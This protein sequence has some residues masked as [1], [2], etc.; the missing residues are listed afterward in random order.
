MSTLKELQNFELNMVKDIVKIFDKNNIFYVICSGTLL[1][2]IRH[3][4]FIPWDDDVDIMLPAKDYKKALK[5]L[6]KELGDK[7]FLQNYHTDKKYNLPWSQIR[8]DGT[9]SMPKNINYDI[10]YGMCF[11]LFPVIGYYKSS[12]L[13]NL[14]IKLCGL[15]RSLLAVDYIKAIDEECCGK[16][17]IISYIPRIV[18]HLFVDIMN[19]FII[20]DINKCE[21]CS[22]KDSG[23]NSI[24]YPVKFFQK[25]RKY[26]FE[27]TEFYGIYDYDEYLTLIYGDYMQLPP[28]DK[29]GGH[30]D[31]LG[32]IIFDLNKNY[33]Y[34]KNLNINTGE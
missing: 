33:S 28:E 3:K 29:R 13:R 2:A 15:E 24:L 10:H 16:Q 22:P 32:D 26:K 30:T 1:G 18:R 17:K 14:Q 7:Y 25:R 34:Y 9:T 11:D 12:S 8:A 27:D 31:E 6:H 20:R 23:Y 4:G 21:L 5:V 19:L